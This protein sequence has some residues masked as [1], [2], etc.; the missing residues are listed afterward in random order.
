MSNL[1]YTFAWVDASQSTFNPVTMDVEDEEIVSFRMTHEEGQIPTLDITVRNPRIG[2]LAPSRKTWA[3]LGRRDSTGHL[4][5]IYFGN[6]QGIPSDLFQ[7]KVTLKFHSRAINFVALKQDAAEALKVA[8][9]YDG[10]WLDDQHRDDPDSILEGWSALW[11]I[12]RKT[13]AI[14]ASD[15]L[16]G[17]DGTV[18]F[19][20]DDAIYSSV[21]MKLGTAPLVNLRVEASVSWQQRTSGYFDVP[22]VSIASYTGDSFIG[23]WPKAGASLGGGYRV[24]SSFV[25]D[26]YNVGLTPTYS[27]ESS[28][29][30]KDPNPGQCSNQSATSKSS[31]PALLSP[32]PLTCVLTGHFQTGI[33]DPFSDPPTN[34]PMQLSVTGVVIPQWQLS[35]Q[36]QLRYDA[37]RQYS[38]VLQFD[39]VANVQNVINSPTVD[40]NTELMT[41]SAV[42]VGKPLIDVR[43]WTDF[44]GQH[45]SQTQVI[46]P[47]N[48]T[49]PG[50]LAYQI[51]VTAGTAGSTE[52][53][54]PDLPGLLT[55]DGTVVWA[56]LGKSGLS[57]FPKWAPAVPTPIGQ[58]V[59]LQDREFN[60]A[61][62][63]FEF[64]PGATTYLLCL[65]SG[66]T[67]PDYVE[68]T[69]TPPVVTNDEGPQAVKKINIDQPPTFSQA[70]GQQ[71]TDGTVR[72]INLGKTPALL[73]IPIGGTPDDV[74]AR[75]FFP[76]PRGKIAI[77]Y[78]LC[79]ARARLRYRSRAVNVSWTAP[80]ELVEQ[81]S[82]RM[83]ATLYDPRFPG[84]AVTG[85]VS[86]YSLSMEDGKERGEVTIGCAVGYGFSVT[87]ITGT[88]EYA[89]PGYAQ[90]GWQKYDGRMDLAGSNDVLYTQPVFT[91]FDDGLKFPLRWKDVSDGGV[92]SGT[93]ADQRAA[94]EESFKIAQLLQYIQSWGGE[95]YQKGLTINHIAGLSPDQAW[96]LEQE[97][98]SLAQLNTPAVMRANGISWTCLI[99]PC[100]GN[101]PFQG[102]Y[103]VETSTLEVPQG[104][105]LAAPSSP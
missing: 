40:Q 75:C 41:I 44:R 17:E 54:F 90:L 86:S 21:S 82:G 76:T 73:S 26:I 14:T 31:G 30:N 12:D 59:L 79:K 77:E 53:E 87:P 1:R 22:A 99:K 80:F 36:M 51:C 57:E 64:I 93:L 25:N 9:Y 13:L 100:A 55:N 102:A 91:P 27:F 71:I 62:G 32:N 39:M 83:N 81:L 6:L 78:L 7:E 20:E 101:G 94:I 68:Y 103:F 74:R 2:L 88:P 72:W 42:D 97:Q 3:W 34:I 89:L 85:K 23:E 98:M 92:Q 33:C 47:N 4:R 43:A 84:G 63:D 29:D 48:P 18:T 96:H 16:E 37:Q 67:N 61:A 49:E 45:V 5:G 10:I 28:W 46:W 69:F 38:E 8:P 24:E 19:T 50:G 11:H 66:T 15:V 58:I 65:Q 60:P 105:N 52:P 70:V 95:S 56:C 35:C 104:I